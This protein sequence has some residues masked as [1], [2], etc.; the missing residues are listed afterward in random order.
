[1]CWSLEVSLLTFAVVFTV[2]WALWRRNQPNDRLLAVFIFIYGIMQLFEAGMWW[3]IE[4]GRCTPINRVSTVLAGLSV[5]L[6]PMAIVMGLTLDKNYPGI[7]KN[8]IWK[9]AFLAS[10]AV[11]AYGVY[12]FLTEDYAY[13]TLP[14]KKTGHLYWDF[15]D[16]YSTVVLPV[17]TLIAFLFLKPRSFLIATVVFY[18]SLMVVTMVYLRQCQYGPP[19]GSLW[20][21]LVAFFA[22]IMYCLNP[23]L[24]AKPL[25]SLC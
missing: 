2:S 5:Y 20:C 25:S 23:Y 8:K 14:D 16:S 1:M 13:C 12:R 21:W 9:C 10:L 22:F 18:F 15:P 7:M 19:G 6:H 24:N 17:A 4:D 3:G 11:F